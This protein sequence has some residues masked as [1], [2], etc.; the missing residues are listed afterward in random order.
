MDLVEDENKREGIYFGAM[1]D[2]AIPFIL[3]EAKKLRKNQ[4][5]FVNPE[6]KSLKA[7]LK[8]ADKGNYKK[9]IIVGEDELKEGR[10]FEKEL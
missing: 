7:H 9:A 5:V 4:K 3:K 2:E 8:A 1:I 10:F 6:I